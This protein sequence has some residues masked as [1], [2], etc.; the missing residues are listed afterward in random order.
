MPHVRVFTVLF[1]LIALCASSFC[2]LVSPAM[3]HF[4]MIVPETNLPT[5]QKKAIGLDIRFWHPMDD[6]GM[7]MAKPRLEAVSEGRKTDLSGLLKETKIEGKTAW[8]AVWEA[9]APGVTAFLVSPQPYFEPAEDTFIVH[10]SKT[11]VS[12]LGKDEGWDKPVGAKVEIVPLTR[13]FGIFAGMSFTGKALFKGKPL[14]NAVVEVEWFNKGGTVKLPDPAYGSQAVKTDDKGV[15]TFT[16]PWAGWWGFAV[17][18]EDDAKMK[19]DGKD[20][21]VELG[22][23]L[24]LFAHPQPAK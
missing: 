21:P 10:Y 16:L 2:A 8:T 1:V 9:K 7:D 14:A 19:K 23:I 17:L 22:G 24:W 13:P 4:G 3:A 11:Y 20:K 5:P 18:T 12:A 15:F 6:E